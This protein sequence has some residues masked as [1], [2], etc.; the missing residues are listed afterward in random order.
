MG[1]ALLLIVFAPLIIV[2]TLLAAA[3][4]T[5]G[6]LISDRRWSSSAPE[7]QLDRL[8]LDRLPDRRAPARSQA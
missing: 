3:L 1:I 7:P 2:V 6:Q 5:L 8:E 4:W